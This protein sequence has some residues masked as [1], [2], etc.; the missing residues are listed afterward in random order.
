MLLKSIL[1]GNNLLQHAMFKNTFWLYFGNIANKILKFGLI[2]YAARILGPTNYG[3]FNYTL[4]L[5]GAI[6]I[7]SDLGIGGLMVREY[8]RDDFDKAKLV[9]TGIAMRFFLLLMTSII[10]IVFFF[11]ITDPAVKSIFLLLLILSLFNHINDVFVH[12]CRAH[13]RMDYESRV[14]IIESFV[15]TFL[16]LLFLHH[17]GS[18]VWYALAYLIG[19]ICG[20]IY[21][22]LLT[23][24]YLY[25]IKDF[26]FSYI[27]RIM[28]LALPFV[29]GSVVGI[30]LF[31]TDIIILGW[32][33]G[34]EIVG[35]YSAGSRVVNVLFLFSSLFSIVLFP[36]FSKLYQTRDKFIS[37]LKNS[38]S[39]ISIL[40]FPLWIGGVLVAEVLITKIYGLQYQAGIIPFQ[41]LLFMVPFIYI[42]IILDTALFALNYQ[43]QNMIF[44]SIA[45]LT[46]VILDLILVPLYSMQGSAVATVIAQII[47]FIL[48]YSLLRKVLGQNILVR[49]SLLKSLGSSVVMGGII[50]WLLTLS[51]SVL[52]IIPVA[53]IFYFA[54]LIFLK[55]SSVMRFINTGLQKT[56]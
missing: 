15:T 46:N 45:A 7:F 21:L 6:F 23:S 2:V 44:T 34:N 38:I 54:I 33:Q 10:A 35:Q 31:N 3:V 5:V 42:T 1:F 48:T 22:G 55:E 8:Q 29:F 28:V 51:I 4:S 27:K 18:I 24:K 32:I 56:T 13:H 49:E 43:V 19:I 53:A 30:I 11:F 25:S 50:I 26:C 36:I 40:G 14:I 12:L 17:S 39:Y 47:N 20:T 41:I 16:G 37:I 9:T 52:F